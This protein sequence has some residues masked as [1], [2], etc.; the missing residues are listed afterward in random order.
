MPDD[1]ALANMFRDP[2]GQFL[3]EFDLHVAKNGI[4]DPIKG[5][6]ADFQNP[7]QLPRE[8]LNT[9]RLTLTIF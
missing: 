6:V 9:P 3:K 4:W 8:S 2:Y 7:N 5:A 1:P